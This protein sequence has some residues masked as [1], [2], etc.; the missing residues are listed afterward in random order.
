MR[1]RTFNSDDG[2]L[3]AAGRGYREAGG[4]GKMR[5]KDSRERERPRKENNRKI[6]GSGYKRE[7]VSQFANPDF[8]SRTSILRIYVNS[9]NQF[10]PHFLAPRYQSRPGIPNSV[11]LASLPPLIGRFAFRSASFTSR[12]LTHPFPTPPT[13]CIFPVAKSHRAVPNCRLYKDTLAFSFAPILP[14]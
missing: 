5:S 1:D 2:E 14:Y 6:G 13:M 9:S 3:A 11:H 4:T 12:P 7:T 10:H 8:R